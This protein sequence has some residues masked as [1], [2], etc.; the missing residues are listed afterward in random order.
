MPHTPTHPHRHTH[1]LL[2]D[3]FII[4][5]YI[6][7][8][9]MALIAWLIRAFFPGNSG[10]IMPIS[11]WC[12]KSKVV[13]NYN[14]KTKSEKAKSHYLLLLSRSR[15][16]SGRSK[17]DRFTPAAVDCCLPA[18]DLL[19]HTHTHSLMHTH[20]HTQ[21]HTFTHTKSHKQLHTT[22]HHPHTPTHTHTHPH[23]PTHT[24]THPH[25]PSH[26]GT[27]RWP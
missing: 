4:I 5:E 12:M 24:H 3:V 19:T 20:T 22:R 23:T 17:D 11:W 13:R 2:A 8:I 6:W 18:R 27:R 9:L 21:R 7:L 15:Y 25:T 10:S 16:L 1:T 26:R 14:I